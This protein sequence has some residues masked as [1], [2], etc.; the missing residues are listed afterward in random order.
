MDQFFIVIPRLDRGIQLKI[1][2]LISILSY[3]F[4][5]PWSSHGMTLSTFSKPC[6]RF[7]LE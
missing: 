7:Y 2:K 6:N 5:I 4:G 3:F 1:F